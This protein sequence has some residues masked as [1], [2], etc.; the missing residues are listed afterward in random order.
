MQALIRTA[1][2][3]L[4]SGTVASITSAV[5]L[6]ALAR[7]EGRAPLQPINATSHWLHGQQAAAFQGLDLSR[8][9]IGYATHHAATVFWAAFFARWMAVRRPQGTASLLKDAILMSAI[10]AAVDYGATPKR[11]TPGWEF[12][13]SKKA[14]AA[15]YLAIAAGLAAGTLLDEQLR[16]GQDQAS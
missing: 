7:R 10:A 16:R 1:R 6:A 11:F 13:L 8:T 9:A 5:A 3:A 2:S 15:A 12:V 4:V 14:M